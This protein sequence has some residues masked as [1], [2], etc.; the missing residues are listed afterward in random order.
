MQYHSC[1]LF[2]EG[3]VRCWGINV[4]GEVMPVLCCLFFGN[5]FEYFQI[6]DGTNVNRNTPV[7]VVGLSSGVIML[8]FGD[9]SPFDAISQ[10]KYAESAQHLLVGSYFD[11]YSK[12]ASISMMP[13][14]TCGT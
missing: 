12:K 11:H 2:S 6:G 4:H 13:P 1:A 7:A 5:V 10:G 3:A 9:V 14:Y 8:V